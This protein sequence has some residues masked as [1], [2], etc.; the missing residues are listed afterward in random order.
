MVAE[1]AKGNVLPYGQFGFLC[2]PEIPPKSEQS[3]FL[4]LPSLG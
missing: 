4:A 2:L 3:V 1:W